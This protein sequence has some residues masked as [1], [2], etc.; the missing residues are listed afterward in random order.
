M[1]LE[2]LVLLPEP[3]A[4]KALAPQPLRLCVLAPFGSYAGKGRLR[5]LRARRTEH[6]VELVCGYESYVGIGPRGG[7]SR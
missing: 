4:R 2:N 5:V 1:S 7:G 6:A 3:A